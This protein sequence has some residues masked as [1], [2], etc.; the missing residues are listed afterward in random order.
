MNA[1]ITCCQSQSFFFQRSA[2]NLEKATKVTLETFVEWKKKKLRE[3]KRKAKQEEKEK[4]KSIKKGD[5]VI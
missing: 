3:R 2:L 4:K 5:A 1:V